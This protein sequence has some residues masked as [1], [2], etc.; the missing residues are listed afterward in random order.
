[1]L[2]LSPLREELTSD[3]TVARV[4]VVGYEGISVSSDNTMAERLTQLRDQWLAFTGAL[5]ARMLLWRATEGEPAVIETFISQESDPDAAVTDD[6]FV[7]LVSPYRSSQAHGHALASELSSHYDELAAE[8]DGGGGFRPPLRRQQE[9]DVQFFVRFLLAL[10]MHLVADADCHLAVWL[11]PAETDDAHAYLLWLQCLVHAAPV[12]LRFMIIDDLAL[13]THAALVV[14]EPKRVIAQPCDFEL[15]KAAAELGASAD[16]DPSAS[17]RRMQQRLAALLEKGE[18][19]SALPIA[20]AATDLAIGQRWPELGAAVQMTLGAAHAGRGESLE[21]L[22]AYAEAER[23][24]AACEAAEAAAVKSRESDQS[25]EGSDGIGLKL[26]LAV[27]LSQG[28]VLIA[29]RAFKQAAELYLQT[30]PLAQAAGDGRGELDCYRL[31]SVCRAQLGEEILAWELGMRGLGCGAALDEE[32]RRTST[33]GF[34]F[35]HLI[36]LTK[37]HGQFA[38]HRRGLEEQAV[39]LLGPDW[40]AHLPTG[41]AA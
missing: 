28:A 26:R 30:V 38:A 40:R 14:A 37:K 4:R 17:F 35:E 12:E 13:T 32:S 2:S 34:L 9:G 27:R 23:L 21:A 1:M 10:R 39:R 15:A 31:A 33:L 7:Q 6:I 8:E 24:A 19:A 3:H 5:E 25:E 11:S 41:E 16:S 29:H 18:L 36:L 22:R 20:K